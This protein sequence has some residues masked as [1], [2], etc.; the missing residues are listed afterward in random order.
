MKGKTIYMINQPLLPHKFQ[1]ISLKNTKQV[2]NSISTMIVRGAPAIGAT[3]AFGLAQAAILNKDIKKAYKMLLKTRPT[4]YDLKDGLDFVY[5]FIKNEKKFSKVKKVAVSAA[6]YYAD[7]SAKR[8]KK[9]GAETLR[10]L[11]SFSKRLGYF[12]SDDNGFVL[13]YF[14]NSVDIGI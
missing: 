10:R 4:A 14:H 8:C 12:N 13:K 5:G 6:Q 1:I 11:K 7:Q 9:I 2:A 3:A